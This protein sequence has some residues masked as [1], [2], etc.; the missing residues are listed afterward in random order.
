MLS[1]EVMIAFFAGAVL[2]ALAMA[3]LAGRARD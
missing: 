3:L 2:G 1:P